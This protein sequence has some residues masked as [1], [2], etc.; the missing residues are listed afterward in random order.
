[1]LRFFH[2]LVEGAAH[3]LVLVSS[4]DFEL[5]GHPQFLGHSEGN[6]ITTGVELL[7]DSLIISIEIIDQQ[8]ILQVRLLSDINNITFIL[9]FSFV[10]VFI[11]F[12]SQAIHQDIHA[13]A[14][15]DE[16]GGLFL[17]GVVLVG[18]LL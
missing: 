7:D 14:L 15:A 10:I 18:L 9:S 16:A 11:L 6:T 3:F 8:R 5:F 4:A 2:L 12:F 17:G 1:M 13:A